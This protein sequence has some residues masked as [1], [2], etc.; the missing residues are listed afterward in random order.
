MRLPGPNINVHVRFENLD[1]YP[2]FDFYLKYGLSNG[3]VYRKHTLTKL[4]SGV[5]TRLEGEGHYLTRVYLVA[6]PRG[7]A[8]PAIPDLNEDDSGWHERTAPGTIQSPPLAV[9]A[10]D[11][12]YICPY[13]ATL[14]GKVLG[15]TALPLEDPPEVRA[16]TRL[17]FICV[18]LA[19]SAV[20]AV[21]LGL[22]LARRLRR[23]TSS[24]A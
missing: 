17:G 18:G 2:D 20:V 7:K 9:S 11:S 8:P 10:E 21:W 1:D 15:A 22:R 23:R 4:A 19:L 24:P 14:E 16:R 3:N 6:V 12:G 13:R 5:A